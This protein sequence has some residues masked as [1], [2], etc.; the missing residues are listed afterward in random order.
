VIMPRPCSGARA[1]LQLSGGERS[2]IR[3]ILPIFHPT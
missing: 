1:F 3:P 2:R